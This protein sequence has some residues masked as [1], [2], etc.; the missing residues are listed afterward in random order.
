[1]KLTKGLLISTLILSVFIAPITADEPGLSYF[2]GNAV[3]QCGL[4]WGQGSYAYAGPFPYDQTPLYVAV[5]QGFCRVEGACL[6][7]EDG[8]L[9]PDYLPQVPDPG[10]EQV[11]ELMEIEGS[12]FLK[13]QWT[14]NNG[15]KHK[16]SLTFEIED[17]TNG[18]FTSAWVSSPLD[19]TP[20]YMETIWLGIN[21]VYENPLPPY[22]EGPLGERWDPMYATISFEGTHNGE[23]IEGKA[24]FLLFHFPDN[25]DQ[26]MFV[27]NLWVE[28]YNVYIG[29]GWSEGS[30][31]A[32]GELN[33]HFD[34]TYDES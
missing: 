11:R 20:K 32:P 6:L 22:I 3:R 34:M 16:I 26:E 25:P 5:F 10:W 12:A 23:E 31:F 19:P 18:I 9:D 30:P 21:L 17:Q 13:G 27:V 2:R 33:Y 29:L 15:E 24:I 28:N 7:G 14:D 1:M 4:I 8:A